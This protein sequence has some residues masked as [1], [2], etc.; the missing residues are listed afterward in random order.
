MAAA[1]ETLLGSHVVDGSGQ[2]VAVASLAGSDK[3]I[4][5]YSQPHNS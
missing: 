4:G 1:L 2:T 5:E 3:V